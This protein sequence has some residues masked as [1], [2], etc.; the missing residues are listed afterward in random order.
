MQR[1]TPRRPARDAGEG[2]LEQQARELELRLTAIRQHLRQPLEAEFARGQLTGPQRS[3]MSAV[4]A[5]AFPMQ[6]GEITRA[7]G[8]AQ[9]TVSGIVDR[10]VESGMLV[11]TADPDDARAKRIAPSPAVRHFLEKRMP[12]LLLSPLLSAL[13]RAGPS[14]VKRICDAV[15][16]LEQLLD[17]NAA[18]V[19]SRRS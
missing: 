4:V 6:L 19:K 1:K 10:L 16:E 9:S 5:S 17:E 12:K 13:R 11:R 14:E 8:L 7:V 18:G 15:A 2:A 3:V